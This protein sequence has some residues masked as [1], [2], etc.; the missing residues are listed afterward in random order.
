MLNDQHGMPSFDSNFQP[1]YE[2]LA[3]PSFNIQHL[4]FNK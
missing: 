2:H 3:L 4:S 1:N